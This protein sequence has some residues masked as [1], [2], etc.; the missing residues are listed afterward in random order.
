MNILSTYLLVNNT[1]YCF[2]FLKNNT[3]V[4]L[5]VTAENS[6]VHSV[7]FKSNFTILKILQML[8]RNHYNEISL[9]RYLDDLLLSLIECYEADINKINQ[10]F[11]FW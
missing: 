11:Y 10:F 5:N 1:Y 2:F 9:K 3:V 7:A 4:T 6:V 8:D